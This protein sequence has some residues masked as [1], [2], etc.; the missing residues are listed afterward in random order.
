MIR[1]G[2]RL[3]FKGGIEAAVRLAVT[4]AAVAIGVCL[5]LTALSGMHALS[6]LNTRAAWLNSGNLGSRR[7]ATGKPASVSGPSSTQTLWWLLGTD[8][9]GDRTIFEA[10]VAPTGPR[11]PIPPG[12]PQLPGPGQYFASPALAQLI[13]STP[14]DELGDRFTGQQIGTIGPSGL[15]SPT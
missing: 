12:I 4:A 15:P 8:S 11:S 10:D 9:F 3:T 5:L 6:A 13:R 2:L 14:A 7:P 1:L